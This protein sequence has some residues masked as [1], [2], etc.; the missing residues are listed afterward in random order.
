ML[1][2]QI[3]RRSALARAGLLTAMAM[4]GSGALAADSATAHPSK[5]QRQFRFCLNMATIR[6]QK[7][8]LIREA[9]VAAK[10][11]YHGIEPWVSTIEEYAKSGGS[12]KEAK[13]RIAEL[14][15]AVECAIGFPEWVVDDDARRA[16]GLERMKREMDL[17][18]QIGG[19]RI[20]APPSGATKTPGLDLL[21]AAERYR[22]VLELGTQMG[23][24]P[25]LEVWG[26]SSNLRRL[27]ECAFVAIESGHPQAGLLGDVFHL[28]KGGSEFAGLKLL[29]GEALPVFH[30]NDYPAEPGRD[31]INDAARVL[32]GDGVAPLT[33]I[34]GIL[35]STPGTKVLSLELFSRKYWEQDPLDVA[36]AGLASM[37]S[38]SEKAAI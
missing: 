19:R 35:G 34:L 25:L 26:F 37:K 8:G 24:R 11:G 30:L 14:G 31:E 6:G 22:A 10:A 23:V 18:A 36:R 21:K 3:S 12:L 32:P 7:L 16:K 1:K 17:V 5:A 2:Q 33:E 4:T 15:L 13:Q 29:S 9:E 27:G 20:A 28:Y 38:A